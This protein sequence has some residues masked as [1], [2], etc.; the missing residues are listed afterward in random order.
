MA[1]RGTPAAYYPILM[2]GALLSL[3]LG[4]RAEARMVIPLVDGQALF[5]QD[6]GDDDLPTG[7]DRSG[8]DSSGGG[9]KT[10]QRIQKN[11]GY[12]AAS[13]GFQNFNKD[14]LEVSYQIPEKD[15]RAYN[16]SFGYTK[17]G[18]A[19]VRAWRD[20]ATKSA[21]LMASGDDLP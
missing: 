21:F 11:V 7:G 20:T 5:G 17:E 12:R 15:F 16:E 10:F 4:L 1:W 18:L 3:R 8:G 9:P 13:Y 6:S 14:K 2:A 19:A